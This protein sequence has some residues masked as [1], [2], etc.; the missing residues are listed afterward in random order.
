MD[1][2]AVLLVKHTAVEELPLAIVV[3]DGK[4]DRQL[5]AV[6]RAAQIPGTPACIGHIRIVGGGLGQC[7]GMTPELAL[8]TVAVVLAIMVL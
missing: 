2:D 8:L 6:N 3:M 1:G 4:Q 5:V 7:S